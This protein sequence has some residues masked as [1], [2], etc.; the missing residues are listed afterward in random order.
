MVPGT[1]NFMRSDMSF[2]K[3]AHTDMAAMPIH[4]G[5][6]MSNNEA[7]SIKLEMVSVNRSCHFVRAE[8][9]SNS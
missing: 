3:G 1:R 5:F 8:D 2:R 9:K 6:G 7:I 4:I